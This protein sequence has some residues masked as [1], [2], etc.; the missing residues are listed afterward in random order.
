MATTD[1]PPP[2]QGTIPDNETVYDFDE[3]YFDIDPDLLAED[4]NPSRPPSPTES[5]HDESDEELDPEELAGRP[6]PFVAHTRRRA[7][8]L[9]ALEDDEV[10]QKLLTVFD[11]L[12]ATG[13]DLPVFLEAVCWGRT[14][15]VKNARIRTART[16]LMLSEQLP[17]IMQRCL[18]PPRWSSS[19]RKKRA[20]GARAELLPRVARLCVEEMKL[21]MVL[22]GP[23]L[24]TNTAT[25]VSA[26]SLTGFTF[27]NM[28]AEMKGKAP[29]L[30]GVLDSLS[31]RHPSPIITVT[32]IAQLM[33]RHNR[34][35][36]R[37]Q[38]TYSVYFKFKGLSAKGFDVL[39][40]LGL[41]MSHAWINVAVGRMSK[42]TLD[43]MRELIR[44]YPWTLTYDNIVIMFKVFA[45][46]LDN[47]QK[48]TNGTA[49]TVYVTP[50]AKPLPRAANA[51]L[52]AQRAANLHSPLTRLDIFRLVYKGHARLRPH[53]RWSI[54]K[55]LLDCP[56]FDF[57]TYADKES[58]LLQPPPPIDALP[59]GKDSKSKQFLLGSVNRPEA[60]YTDH[61]QL[62]IEW[63][64]QL[65]L[66][67]HNI[68]TYKSPGPKGG[69]EYMYKLHPAIPTIRTNADFVDQT[70]NTLTRGKKHTIPKK[71]NDILKLMERVKGVHGYQ[72]GRKCA[73]E[74]TPKDYFGAG[75][76]KWMSG[77]TW[78]NWKGKRTF[79]RS[80]EENY[81]DS[82][83]GDISD[84]SEIE[85]ESE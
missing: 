6:S 82:G 85:I 5:V 10:E 76:Q 25:D 36:N 47:Q 15:A 44:K 40:G 14:C 54:I 60:S 20:A 62:I 23:M 1:P 49:A 28:H 39:H 34:N 35:F 51:A 7:E 74:D 16:T 26:A 12:R 77:P 81:K 29:L 73:A 4:L 56:D 19:T 53:Y 68:V 11:A 30:V 27:T 17:V 66:L 59:T 65:D 48:L 18:K 83:K 13:M 58:P 46:R 38:K 42:M 70:F 75:G 79:V 67:G 57:A 21:E 37:I 50:G 33:Y 3:D 55:G 52:K 24:T 2:T 78:E 80:T 31:E 22:L 64:K 43:E 84:P 9:A 61:E 45:Q 32:T 72:R 8:E 71:E 41:V 63:L 69:W